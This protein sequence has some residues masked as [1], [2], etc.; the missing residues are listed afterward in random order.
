MSQFCPTQF[1]LD[2]NKWNYAFK[3][4]I[5]NL[6]INIFG[7][8]ESPE[9]VTKC[10]EDKIR[11]TWHRENVRIIISR[12]VTGEGKLREFQE[13]LY[14]R[15]IFRVTRERQHFLAGKT[16]TKFAALWNFHQ[17]NNFFNFI[18]FAKDE[19]S[20]SPSGTR[21]GRPAKG[22][23]AAKPQV[24]DEDPSSTSSQASS[25]SSSPSCSV[26]STQLSGVSSS[27]LARFTSSIS[28]KSGM[29]KITSFCQCC[30]FMTFWFG[31]GSR[32]CYFCHW[33]SGRQQKLIF[34]RSFLL[35]TFWKYIYI[36]FQRQKVKRS[37][38]NSRNR[39]CSYYFFFM[40]E[41]SDPYLW[42]TDPDPDPGG[43][44]S[45]G[46]GQHWFLHC[47]DFF[48]FFLEDGFIGPYWVLP[49]MILLKDIQIQTQRD[50][51]ASRRATTFATHLP[52]DGNIRPL[53]ISSLRQCFGSIF[54][55][56]GSGSR[57]LL[58]P[59]PHP[60]PLTSMTKNWKV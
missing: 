20:E 31:S 30:G 46:S 24:D 32:S 1:R 9:N 58:N 22:A 3:P 52:I 41:G 33:P 23:Q 50:A 49:F 16:K 5:P 12:K 6:Y 45:Y 34:Y 18:N 17:Q 57:L 53:V 40:I 10:E 29:Q 48:S 37:K 4:A 38:K 56:T 25:K 26:A 2:E 60:E 36:I 8:T 14:K 59:E 21:S 11:F 39:G 51:V 13:V 54:I 35:I 19:N 15:K 55:E 44:K 47:E 28:R 27:T 42:L 7:K 43:P